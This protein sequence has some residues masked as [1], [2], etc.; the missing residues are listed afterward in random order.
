MILIA[1]GTRPEWL[2]IKPIIAEFKK[3]KVNYKV[4][5][6]G[7]HET[8]IKGEY[9]IKLNIKNTTENRLNNI[10]ASILEK[11]DFK[12]YNAVIVQGDTSSALSIA[13][14]A[15]NSSIKVIHL[16]AGLRTYDKYSPYPEEVNRQL[17]SRMSDINLC[18]T[19]ANLN[20]LISEQPNIGVKSYVVGNTVLDNLKDIKVTYEKNILITL[21]RRE[22]IINIKSW[23]KEI[24]NLARIYNDY[25]FIFPM[26]PNPLIQ[27]HRNI[28]S[29]VRVVN[30][31]KHKNFIDIL[32]KC[33][34]IIS[35][36]GGI[37]EEASFLNKKIIVTRNT[38]ERTE[39]LNKHSFLCEKPEFLKTHFDYHIKNPVVNFSCPYGNGNASKII[40][41]ILKENAIF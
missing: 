40:Y 25:D 17:I 15:F 9:D 39:S 30:P 23:F 32:A 18:P 27:Q 12:D 8:L 14:A 35:D 1:Y 6:S 33:S 24:N 38:T 29:E 3:R 37:Q 16:E 36:S 20:N 13:L 7:Q 2:K 26:H 28:L 19:K 31:L 4:L 5:F 22:N 11:M 34:L 41:D 21:H 10:C